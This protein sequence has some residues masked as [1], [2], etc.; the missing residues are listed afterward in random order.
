MPVFTAPPNLAHRPFAPSPL[1]HVHQTPLLITAHHI[2]L[3]PAD[4][5]KKPRSNHAQQRRKQLPRIHKH[6]QYP[7]LARKL[8]KLIHLVEVV[9]RLYQVRSR[10]G[11]FPRHEVQDRDKGDAGREEGEEP[12]AEQLVDGDVKDEVLGIV[13]CRRFQAVN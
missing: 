10:R 2:L 4:W 9:L 12:D 8:D 11:V 6:T 1:H 3:H 13:C 7:K 5:P